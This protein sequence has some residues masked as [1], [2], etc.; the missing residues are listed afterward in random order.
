MSNKFQSFEQGC[1]V[2]PWNW[3]LEVKISLF[4]FRNKLLKRVLVLRQMNDEWTKNFS[5][6]ILVTYLSIECVDFAFELF[7]GLEP[8]KNWH[9]YVKE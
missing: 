5:W 1:K 6:A 4:I 7:Q 9:V 2:P 8:I 3:F